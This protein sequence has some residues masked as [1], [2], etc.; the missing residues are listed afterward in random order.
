MVGDGLR[1]QAHP[2]AGAAHTPAEVDVV[3][4][5]G[6][7]RVEPAQPF[8]HVAADQHARAGDGQDL[9]GAVV[10]TVV[11]LTLFQTGLAAA[12]PVDGDTDL[13]QEPA[14]EPVTELGAQD[15]GAG[16]VVRRGQQLFEGV[17]LR[18]EVVVDQPQPLGGVLVET[19]HLGG[20]TRQVQ[21][22]PDRVAVPGVVGQ[23][24]HRVV[25]QV[26]R[27]DVGASVGAAGVGRHHTLDRPGLRTQ[28]GQ[29]LRQPA[30]SV[31]GHDDSGDDVTGG[32]Q[33]MHGCGGFSPGDGV[34]PVLHGPGVCSGRSGRSAP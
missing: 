6:Q 25:G 26:I 1:D 2:Q 9:A 21:G 31:V 15:S 16:V 17:L 12:G 5:Q 34:A 27:E 32:I 30:C 11:E 13:D 23:V 14:V 29:G 4:E 10:L 24:D 8:P 3:A 18:G 20:G 33:V 22:G 7:R 19:P 28:R